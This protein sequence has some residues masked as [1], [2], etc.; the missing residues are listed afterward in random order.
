VEKVRKYFKRR[1]RKRQN[2]KKERKK[3]YPVGAMAKSSRWWR[4]MGMA[5]F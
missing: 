5:A 4:R 1:K 2:Q 3:K